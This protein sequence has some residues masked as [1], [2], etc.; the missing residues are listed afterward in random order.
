MLV[1]PEKPKT[2]ESAASDEP[3]KLEHEKCDKSMGRVQDLDTDKDGKPELLQVF[4]SNNKELCRAVDFNHDGKPDMYEYY[5][6]DGTLRRREGAYEQHLDAIWRSPSSRR[7]S[8]SS[9]SATRSA[10]ARLIR[11]TPTTR[12]RAS[13]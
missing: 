3:K 12:R 9:A 6:E 5:N 2:E 13:S 4:N 11:G 7:A 8:S 1:H 10:C